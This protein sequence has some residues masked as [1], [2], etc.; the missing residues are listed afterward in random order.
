MIKRLTI[1]A[2]LL[3]T[4]ATASTVCVTQAQLMEVLEVN[5]ELNK[6]ASSVKAFKQLPVQSLEWYQRG[7]VR[8]TAWLIGGQDMCDFLNDTYIQPAEDENFKLRMK[9]K[10]L[11]S[12]HVE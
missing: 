1:V 8:Y 7:D 5:N 11:E 12:K 10:M 9:I 3:P 6:P 4:L 2:A